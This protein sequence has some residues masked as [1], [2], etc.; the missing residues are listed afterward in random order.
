DAEPCARLRARRDPQRDLAVV[1]RADADLGAERRLRQVDRHRAMD[2]EAVATEEPVRQDLERDDEV[3]GRRAGAAL[4]ALTGEAELRAVV[5]AGRHGQHDL[6]LLADLTGAVA[7]G[8]ALA[9][10]LA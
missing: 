2:V 5:D 10:D 6:A 3:A 7:G 9:R 4:L 1:D 8:A